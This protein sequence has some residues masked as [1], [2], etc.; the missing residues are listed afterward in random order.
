M[1]SL[2]PLS[3]D[4][5]F[6]LAQQRYEQGQLPAAILIL[7]TVLAQ[8]PDHQAAASLL[9]ALLLQDG[10]AAAAERLIRQTLASGGD[11]AVLWCNLGTS[12]MDQQRGEEALAAYAAATAR[13]ESFALPWYNSGNLLS[14]AKR[15]EEAVVA[16][17]EALR[18]T[19]REA[20]IW[21]N[22]GNVYLALGNYDESEKCYASAIDCDPND[23]TPIASRAN[24]H[25]TLGNYEA[26]DADLRAVLPIIANSDGARFNLALNLFRQGRYEEGFPLYEHRWQGCPDLLGQYRY[27]PERQWRGENLAGQRILLWTEQ[28]LGDT[29][30]F[31]RFIPAVQERAGE[32]VLVCHPAVLSLFA[33]SFPG[34]T[35]VSRDNPPLMGA[36]DWHCP[37]M[38]LWLALAAP[39][40]PSMAQTPAN[41]PYL[42]VPAASRAAWRQRLDEAEQGL[43]PA[44]LRVGLCWQSGKGLEHDSRSLSLAELAVLDQP[45][46]RF[47]RLLKPEAFRQ[48]E[49][50]P[51]VW[52]ANQADPAAG[53]WVDLAADFNDFAAT[54]ALIETL[55]VVVT[56]DTSVLHIAAALGKPVW[57]LF[58]RVGGNF[59]PHGRS[60]SP[61]YP[62]LVVVRQG[63]AGSWR[64]AIGQVAA[65]LA[66]PTEYPLMEPL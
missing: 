58:P 16:F 15:N 19:P 25:S 14:E 35:V 64:E 57:G 32:V 17:R 62:T 61:W 28:G 24:L 21:N 1:S 7:Q 33:A 6:V 52:Q 66:L 44:R 48:E 55:D 51:P 29:L 38:S 46:L 4:Q 20:R 23:P 56:V 41:I 60:D 12:L 26:A 36:G 8:A 30:Q 11:S 22:L 5:A 43:P 3:A 31:A 34:V 10:Q 47:Y 63:R 18:R 37:L 13:D 59:F 45:D 9:A 50:P 42:T 65:A 53:R 39:G 27:P 40:L 49:P 2:I 54:A